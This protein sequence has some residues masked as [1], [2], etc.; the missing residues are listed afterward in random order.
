MMLICFLIWQS[1]VGVDWTHTLEAA[2]A[3]DI[4]L[5]DVLIC[6]TSHKLLC[7]WCNKFLQKPHTT[8]ISLVFLMSPGSSSRAEVGAGF[9]YWAAVINIIQNLVTKS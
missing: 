2:S 5:M 8:S 1:S 4:D 3:I 6:S 9:T 7:C